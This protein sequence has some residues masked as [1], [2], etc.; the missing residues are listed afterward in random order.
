MM[1]CLEQHDQ[2]MS[3]IIAHPVFAAFGAIF[4]QLRRSIEYNE[5]SRGLLRPSSPIY[6]SSF[7]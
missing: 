3:S 5:E 6:P 2:T 7:K 1:K 4:T